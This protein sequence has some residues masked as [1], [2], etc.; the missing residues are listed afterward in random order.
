[1][2]ILCVFTILW[3]SG[4]CMGVKWS[5]CVQATQ[6][7][8]RHGIKRHS[9]AWFL[10]RHGPWVIWICHLIAGNTILSC[11]KVTLVS[12][13]VMRRIVVHLNRSG[14]MLEK[15]SSD[16]AYSLGLDFIFFTF[17]FTFPFFKALVFLAFANA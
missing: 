16:T 2:N 6:C 7:L 13:M 11:T 3:C 15:V 10:K 4:G 5:K 17:F 12:F 1:M 9:A 8:K 14:S